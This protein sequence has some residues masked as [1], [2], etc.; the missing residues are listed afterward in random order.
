[1]Y[2]DTHEI[3]IGT[4]KIKSYHEL[5]LYEIRV[6]IVPIAYFIYGNVFVVKRHSTKR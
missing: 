1:M 4:Y 5:S 6:E 3:K 2:D